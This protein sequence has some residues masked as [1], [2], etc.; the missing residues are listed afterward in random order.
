M[1]EQH[2]APIAIQFVDPKFLRLQIAGAESA[3]HLCRLE[4]ILN[5]LLTLCRSFEFIVRLHYNLDGGLIQIWEHELFLCQL[6]VKFLE[7]LL[8]LFHQICAGSLRFEEQVIP[9]ALESHHKEKFGI[10]RF[11][12]FTTF[13]HFFDL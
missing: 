8:H 13:L 11:F 9:S 6:R 4:R 3:R 2:Q 1:L 7:L 12:R 5:D 10:D